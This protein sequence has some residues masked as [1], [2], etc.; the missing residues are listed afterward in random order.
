MPNEPWPS[1]ARTVFG[2]RICHGACTLASRAAPR[3][4]VRGPNLTWGDVHEAGSAVCVE[5]ITAF[6]GVVTMTNTADVPHRNTCTVDLSPST[7]RE[8]IGQ[9]RLVS[10]F[11]CRLWTQHS[12]PEEQ[13]TDEAC[14][15]LRESIAKHGQHQPALGRPVTTDPDYD[16]EIIC[17]ARRHAVAL[18]LGRNLLLEVRAINDAEAY[19]AMY[20]ENAE[21]EDDCAY[22]KGQILRRALLSGTY[23]CQEALVGA[24]SLSHS[25]ISRLL[26]IAQL[27]S[28]IVAAFESPRDIRESWGLELYQLWKGK[29]PEHGLAA[30]ARS[31]TIRHPRPSARDVYDI[32]ITAS[33]GKRA[34]QRANRNI[35]IRG[36]SGHVL[37]R[38]QDQVGTVMFT[39]P[40]TILSPRRRDALKRAMLQIL[41]D[42]NSQATSNHPES[43]DPTRQTM[44]Q[45][46]V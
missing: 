34:T 15:S 29:D 4:P 41:D 11:R 37:F 19:I 30:R 18:A 25:K 12:R 5:V 33:G 45:V 40:K 1:N 6:D 16:V 2:G 44:V 32:L 38:E 3:H 36:S 14:K 8:A 39:V 9:R 22:V 42:D 20:Q 7:T 23:S 43:Q 46:P 35:P 26:M 10:P 27:P 31:V 13:L 21:R 24:F 28:V 17:G